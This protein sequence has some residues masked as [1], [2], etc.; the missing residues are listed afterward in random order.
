[1]FRLDAEKLGQ[2][3][4]V[5]MR[6]VERGAIRNF[7]VALGDRNPLYLS[8]EAARA[9][10]YRDV[11]APPT[12]AVTLLPWDIPGLEMPHAGVLHGEQEFEWGVPICAGDEIGVVGWVDAVKARSGQQGRM[13]MITVASEGT[14]ENQE[15]AF[16]ARAVLIVTEEAANEHGR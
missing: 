16:R 15:M 14:N 6:T 2:R 1:M 7:A 5:A 9:Q 13:T 4:P 10:G 11:V 12:F 8:V 3:S